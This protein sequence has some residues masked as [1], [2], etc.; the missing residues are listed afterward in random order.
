VILASLRRAPCAVSFSG[1]RDSS[2]ILATATAV[3]R[4]EGLPLPIPVTF[5]VPGSQEA[6]E[7][8]WQELV[9]KHLG[10]TNWELIDA[11][12]SFDV[13]GELAA[14]VH[15]RCGLVP[16]FNLHLHE[17]VAALAA[18]GSFLTGAGGDEMLRGHRRQAAA[19]L[20]H[21]G[22][23]PTRS[24]LKAVGAQLVPRVVRARRAVPIRALD[25]FVWLRQ[26]ARRTFAREYGA[27]TAAL[28]IGWDATARM[29]WGQRVRYVL[30]RAFT[31]LGAG[32]GCDATHPF[33]SAPFVDAMARHYGPIG[34]RS[35]R[36]TMAELFGDILPDALIR[37]TTK[38]SFN[39]MFFTER[40]R[41]VASDWNGSG[42]DERLVDVAALTREWRRPD[43]AAM[44]YAMLQGIHFGSKPASEAHTSLRSN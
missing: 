32:H 40:A 20:V 11:R 12:G 18:G 8:A 27:M 22:R 41:S 24:E 37:R 43:P 19:R 2:A 10:I 1:G 17:P 28:P 5:R 38:A 3:A 6:D 34:P 29:W 39:A 13:V 26:S 9:I 21:D 30:D 44:S 16:P 36:R 33:L 15:R 23:L 35:R 7:I 4:R 14:A 25:D 42:V 31:D